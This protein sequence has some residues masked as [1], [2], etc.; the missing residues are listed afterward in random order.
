MR[1]L[2]QLLLL[3]LFANNLVA[4]IPQLTSAAEISVITCGKGNELYSLY[5]HTALRIHDSILHL[6]KV[7]NYGTFDF[8]TKN[9]GLKFVKGD[10]QYYVSTSSFAEFL[11]EYQYD[12][13]S[14]FEQVLNLPQDKKQALYEKLTRTVLSSDRF[15]TYK[16]IDRNCT[17]KIADLLNET[18]GDDV[19]RKVGN[20]EPSYREILYPE[21]NGHFYEQ[22]GTSLFFGTKVDR[23]S[24]KLFLPTE[25]WQSINVAKEN[26]K[27]LLLANKSW[28]VFDEQPLPF[29]WWN[30][31][32]TYLAL[33][34]LIVLLNKDKVTLVYFTLLALLGT[35]FCFSGCYSFHEELKWD[36]NVLLINPLLLAVVVTYGK[37][38][39]KGL[40]ISCLACLGCLGVY[41]LYMINK[42]HLLI[43]L[44]MILA[45]AVLLGKFVFRYRKNELF[46]TKG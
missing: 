16:F 1:N 34:L 9:F 39:A 14:V 38:N 42:I 13:R 4:Q 35:F 41:T 7:Y 29:S 24:E 33:L 17:T 5:G 40:Y 11:E 22:W 6:D 43:L 45:H 12:K 27:P 21:F 36:Y 31:V 3:S 28:L 2:L 46:T 23:R 44:P 18:L 26:G 32:Y 10:L 30:N 19:L 37:R 20:T 15:Y 8:K 25:L